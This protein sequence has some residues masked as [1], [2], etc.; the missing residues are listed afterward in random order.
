MTLAD[1]A[2]ICKQAR[3]PATQEQAIILAWVY[4]LQP[5]QIAERLQIT[6]VS[7][8]RRIWRAQATIRRVERGFTVDDRET[9]RE[10]AEGLWEAMRRLNCCPQAPVYDDDGESVRIH[11]QAVSLDDYVAVVRRREKEAVRSG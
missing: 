5:G 6:V 3:L 7:V 9:V 4:L 10:H 11:G 8:Q 2:R 1:A